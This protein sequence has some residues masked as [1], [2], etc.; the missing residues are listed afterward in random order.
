MEIH[1]TPEQEMQLS[2][3]AADRGRR[4]GDALAQEVLTRFL[5]EE[6]RFIRAVKLGEEELERG[7]YLT[8][9]EVGE[10]IERWF[11]S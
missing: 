7:E 8:N 2:Q 4:D 1:L 5:E 10:R 6:A 11:Q 3:I 9:A